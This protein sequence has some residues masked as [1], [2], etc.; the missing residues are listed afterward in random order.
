MDDLR[1]TPYAPLE[2]WRERA[3]GW[4]RFGYWLEAMVK[5]GVSPNVGS[6]LGGGTLRQYGRGMDMG[7]SERRR[8]EVDEARHGRSHGGRRI[9]CRLRADLPA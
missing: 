2:E 5:E 4:T 3:T 6:F 1:H 8:D 7:P 9:R